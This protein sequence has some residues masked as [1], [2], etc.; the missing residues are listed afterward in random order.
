[1]AAG[2]IQFP[3]DRV[4]LEITNACNFDCSFCPEGIM[5]R[6]HGVM[7]P[8][9]FARIATQLADGPLVN[10]V[11]LH[12]MG[13]PLLHPDFFEL[14]RIGVDHGLFLHLTTNGSRLERES[15]DALLTSGLGEITVSLQTPD[16]ASFE[17]SRGTTM[18]WA[19]Y[20]EGVTR[21]AARATQIPE[22]TPVTVDLLITARQSLLLPA[23]PDVRWLMDA[24]R[25]RA[26][27]AHWTK[28]IYDAAWEGAE[29]EPFALHEA[30]DR[31]ARAAIHRWNVVRLHPRVQFETRQLG[32]WANAFA[33]DRAVRPARVGA[34]NTLQEQFG[35]LWNGDV[36]LCCADYDGKTV[37]GNALQTPLRDILEGEQCR[38]I[39][40]GFDRLRVVHEHCRTCLGGTTRRQA[41]VHQAGSVFYH[42]LYKRWFRDGS[43]FGA[44]LAG[45]TAE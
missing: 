41:L 18:P 20:A 3:I 14:V 13:E 25:L 24:P 9:D 6:K 31:C 40:A 39:R 17:A 16:A 10:R 21:L 26:V 28:R 2:A 37:V 15:V 22:C 19:V 34:C 33:G 11:M 44:T 12:L 5:T 45:P 7:R 38:A 23:K 8:A 42:R 27:L 35:V 36:V 29:A 43:A 1:M 32:D 30:L 4:H